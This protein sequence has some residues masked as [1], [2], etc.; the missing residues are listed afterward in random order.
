MVWPIMRK[1]AMAEVWASQ[2]KPWGWHQV[3]RVVGDKSPL[4][5][6]PH[7]CVSLACQSL[8]RA[9]VK[10]RSGGA[11]YRERFRRCRLR[12]YSSMRRSYSRLRRALHA[13]AT[14]DFFND[15]SAKPLANQFPNTD[16]PD[17]PAEGKTRQ[18]I[19][20][21]SLNFGWANES[22][23]RAVFNLKPYQFLYGDS[24]FRTV[25]FM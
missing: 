16:L 15:P 7:L 8:E 25:V 10:L 18:L 20:S 17:Q 6:K 12:A 22:S 23:L 19:L 4:R 11:R 3:E 1:N 24:E 9:S 14:A 2:L 5:S 21:M 13:F